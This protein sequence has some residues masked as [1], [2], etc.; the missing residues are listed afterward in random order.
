MTI[1][2]E[3]RM[4]GPG[5]SYAAACGLQ[6]MLSNALCA[7]LQARPFSKEQAGHGHCHTQP[8]ARLRVRDVTGG[9]RLLRLRRAAA[10]AAR[11]QAL[12]KRRRR[13]C[14]LP[15]LRLAAGVCVRQQAAAVLRAASGRL[16]RLQ[17]TTATVKG[18]V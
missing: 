8:R 15:Q 1:T 5:G 11:R 12:H 9:Q 3:Q 6:L 2:S 7:P 4:Q 16:Q 18:L 10:A 13:V 14:A 17:R